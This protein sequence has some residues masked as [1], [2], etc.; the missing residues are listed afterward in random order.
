MN[1]PQGFL[2]SGIHCGIKRR[3]PDLG[4]IYSKDSCCAVG[5]FTTNVN[6]SYSVTVSKKNINNPIKAVLVNSGN[7]NCFSHTKGLKDTE[8]IIGSLAKKLR[9]QKKNILFAST[10]VI[11]KNLPRN[12]II[13]S[14][15]HLL[16]GLETDVYKF[17]SSILT[18]DTAKKISLREVGPVRILGFAKGAGMICPRMATMLGFVLTDAKVSRSFLKQI[19]K[20]VIE[21]S[22][23]S[24]S[25]DGC[26]ST[27]DTVF[28]LSSGKV[29]LKKTQLNAFKRGLK[30]VCL[31]L[32]KMIVKDG[33]GVTK[34][35][36]LKIQGAK[37]SQEAKQA[38]LALANSV[39][40]K[41]ALY[42]ED[43]NW[44]RIIAALGQAGIKVNE[45]ICIKATS[46][47]RREIVITVDLK[48]GKASWN[49]YTSDLTPQYVKL[50]AE[51]S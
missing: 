34:F 3:K 6:P 7:A 19:A 40:F 35:I 14:F 16:N 29:A 18:T 47:K 4:L 15:G 43:A 46:L 8:Q 36:E 21:E 20:E 51:Y 11:G 22:F 23:N 37:T 30:E 27:N 45:N 42:G 17:A 13:K 44:G 50:N 9:V 25:V 28:I 5:F 1:L 2:L 24:I 49:F 32:A 41:C 39:L 38:G 31:E 12:K 26:T 10:G 48:R 33:E